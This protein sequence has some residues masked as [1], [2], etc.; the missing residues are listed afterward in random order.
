MSRAWGDTLFEFP[1]MSESTSPSRRSIRD[2]IS[3][4]DDDDPPEV[5]DVL[6]CR[7]GC[8]FVAYV[9][10]WASLRRTQF[11]HGVWRLHLSLGPA[12]LVGDG[13]AG[14]AK[15]EEEEGGGGGEGDGCEGGPY[16]RFRHGPQL[17]G[18]RF[19]LRTMR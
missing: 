3:S 17:R 5:A 13:G 4:D 6:R 1:D 16:F 18:T 8:V 11:S 9:H 7:P 15:V 2:C 12:I 10:D 14:E 19:R